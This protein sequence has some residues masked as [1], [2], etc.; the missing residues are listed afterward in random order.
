MYTGN[1]CTPGTRAHREPVHTGNQCTPGTSAHREPAHTGKS[2][3]QGTSAHRESRRHVG[4]TGNQCAVQV[5]VN[6][7]MF[8]PFTLGIGG[9]CPLE[10]V[11][12]HYCQCTGSLRCVNL[13]RSVPMPVCAQTDAFP[14]QCRTNRESAVCRPS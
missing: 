2:R 12:S 9:S 10:R 14:A 6:S 3:T 5:A 11:S 13:M 7:Y 8:G 1:P 4:L